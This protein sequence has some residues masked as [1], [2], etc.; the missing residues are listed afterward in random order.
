MPNFYDI[1]Y[2]LGVAA[3]APVWLIKPGAPAKVFAAFSQRTGRELPPRDLAKPAVMIH[4]VSLGEMNATR[5][6]IHLLSTHRD[7][8]QFIVSTT[9]KTGYERGQQL[10]G[11][12]RRITLIRYPLDFSAAVARLLDALRPSAV[13]LM[14]LEI[15]PNFMLACERR[16]IPVMLANG[17]ITSSSF[18][19]YRVV[20]PI[21]AR[22]LRRLSRLCVQDDLYAQ[23]FIALGAP[24]QRVH[25]TGTM[26]F[27]SAE[28]ADDVPGA[29]DLAAEVGLAPGHEP[30]WVCGSTGPGEE[31]LILSVYR[32]LLAAHPALRLV[33]VPRHPERFDEVARFIEA[34]HL[35]LLRRSRLPGEHARRSAVI[36]GDT[37]GELRKFYSI[38]DIVFVGRSLVDLGPRQH[39]SDMIEPAA[40]G[41]PIITGPFTA[42]F[43]EAVRRF[44]ARDALVEV[45][46]AAELRE[47]V[48][49]LLADSPAAAERGRRGQQVVRE[50]QGATARHVEHLLELLEGHQQ[51]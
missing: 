25:I 9:T 8:L 24:A 12:D 13:V 48:S 7:D 29:S 28:V 45:A 2:A 19:K 37:M 49:R 17:R 1:A 33:L 38:A 4:A 6:L 43:A 18:A 46:T 22:M 50:A 30:V 42:N 5:A 21:T 26:K 23:R 3:L 36:L 51:A 31:E 44:R 27:D 39:G 40:L 47:A 34:Q 35:P 32:E 16:G 10:Y 14:E 11:S 15:W 20:R 41:K